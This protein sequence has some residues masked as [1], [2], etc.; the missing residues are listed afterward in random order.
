[1]A[2]FFVRS[3]DGN[4][5]DNGSTWALAKA[6]LAGALAVAQAGDTVYVSDNHNES[7]A[8]ALTLTSLG[9]DF[10]WVRI[11]CVDDTGDPTNPTTLATT[12]VVASTGNSN[13]INFAGVASVFGITFN[14]G[15]GANN[16]SITF[17]SIT[18][19]FWDFENCALNIGGSNAGGRIAVG[20]ATTTNDSN[21]LVLSNTTV[22]FNNNSHGFLIAGTFF[23]WKNTNTTAAINNS[24]NVLFLRT[25]GFPSFINVHGVDLSTL[26]SGK[27]L[28]SQAGEFGGAVIVAN[29]KLNSN[30]NIVTGT[31]VNPGQAEI[32][33]INCATDSSILKNYK[34]NYYGSLVTSTTVVRTGGASQ[35]GTLFSWLI[36]ISTNK[37]I[38]YYSP[39]TTL[40]IVGFLTSTGSKT[41]TISYLHNGANAL[42]DDEIWIELEY[43]G[44][45][46]TTVGYFATDRKA[47]TLTTA[48][49]QSTDTASAW[50]TG[51]TARA[52]STAYSLNDIRRAA[53][54]NG[55]SFIVTTA[56]TSSGSEPAGFSTA[57]DGDSVTDNTVTWRCM[58]REKVNVTVTVNAVGAY[59]AKVN[60]A[61]TNIVYIDP[62]VVL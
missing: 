6:T 13:H 37:V 31:T 61:S 57:N 8:A 16:S 39:F 43:L 14:C 10:N 29:C 55:R 22:S 4:N 45:S 25:A 21:G 58:R 7:T 32:I 44:N 53:T 12:A 19:W 9:I 2:N 41:F 18:P 30:V 26:A 34:Y 40:P 11:L 52:N 5:A 59:T 51:L 42:Q 36:S 20:S 15:T 33:A 54:P 17:T 48:A 50:D 38:K 47:T 35:N 56:G 23:E 28:F 27:A 60:I 49:N 62:L 24:P 1:M 46:S 3:S